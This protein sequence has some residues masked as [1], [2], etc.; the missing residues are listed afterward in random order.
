MKLSAACRE[1][2]SIIKEQH[3]SVFARLPRNKLQGTH[4]LPNSRLLFQKLIQFFADTADLDLNAECDYQ[5]KHR[6]QS[7][8]I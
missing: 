7:H 4:L 1:E 5:E 3:N 2:S 8:D 6:D